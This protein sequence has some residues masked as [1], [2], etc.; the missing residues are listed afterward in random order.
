MFL[1]YQA[2]LE[3]LV[4]YGMSFWYGNLTAKLKTKLACLVHTAMKVI[5]KSD[6]Q[7]LQSIYQQ[8]VFRQAQTPLTSFIQSMT[9]YPQADNTESLTAN[10][11]VLRIHLFQPPLPF[12][13]MLLEAEVCAIIFG[14]W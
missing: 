9:S 6:Y 7:T 4:R 3:S 1:F 10:S 2:V 11:T 12:L 5:G 14:K 8:I 13:T